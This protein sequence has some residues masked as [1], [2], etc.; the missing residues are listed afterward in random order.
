MVNFVQVLKIYILP[1]LYVKHVLITNH[2]DDGN[3]THTTAITATTIININNIYLVIHPL[4][5]ANLFLYDTN[6]VIFNV[7][8]EYYRKM[9]LL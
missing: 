4:R 3:P 5:H 8:M 7:K 6:R 1:A 9:I 2:Q